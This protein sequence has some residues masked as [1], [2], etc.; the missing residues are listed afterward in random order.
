MNCQLCQKE[1]EAYLGG[2]LPS[3]TRTQVE[4]HLGECKD[5]AEYYNLQALAESVINSEKELLPN[6]FLQTRIMARIEELEIS[7]NR[8]I[9][10]YVR[11]LRPAIIAISMAAAVFF[12]VTMGNISKPAAGTDE[13]PVELALIDDSRIESVDVLSN[14]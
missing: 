13:I 10:V 8:V 3:V 14:E 5:C 6:P 1:S 11:A 4:D 9:P 12:G 2:G 7:T